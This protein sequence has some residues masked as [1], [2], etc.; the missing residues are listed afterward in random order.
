MAPPKGHELELVDIENPSVPS[1]ATAPTIVEKEMLPETAGEKKKKKDAK[2]NKEVKEKENSN[3]APDAR[4][5]DG[6]QLTQ[7]KSKPSSKAKPRPGSASK[8]QPTDES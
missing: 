4:G 2:T 8:V 1:V 5:M 6:Q 7:S 3:N